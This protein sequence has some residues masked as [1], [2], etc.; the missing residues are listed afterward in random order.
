[1]QIGIGIGVDRGGGVR[2]PLA[3]LAALYG[4]STPGDV[5]LASD[6]SRIW[7]DAG[8]TPGAVS[9]SI[10]RH[11]GARA[12]GTPLQF[13]QASS[14]LRPRLARV[15]RGG[16]RNRLTWT[17]DLTNAIW[18]KS[19]VTVTPDAQTDP[20]GGLADKII[21]TAVSGGK[22][23][24]HNPGFSSSGSWTYSR[25]VK[26]DGYG[27]FA[28]ALANSTA[29]AAWFNLSTGAITSVGANVTATSAVSLGNGWW[30]VS[31]TT[32]QA[33]GF[34]QEYVSNA[35]SFAAM[36]GDGVSGILVGSAQWEDGA[37]ATAYQ[38]VSDQFDVTEAGV[39]TVWQW[40][41]D[42]VDDV[43]SA[44]VSFGATAMDVFV[45][46]ERTANAALATDAA[47]SATERFGMTETSATTAPHDGAGTPAYYVN[48]TLVS[49]TQRGALATA[50]PVNS[51]RIVEARG[52]DLNTWANL[53]LGFY[54]SFA[55]LSR[56]R[57]IMAIDSTTAAANRATIMAA[58]AEATGV[59]L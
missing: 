40:A 45:V 54:T 20:T 29:N 43:I 7:Q 4:A 15:P 55:G 39:E 21:P 8:V 47:G 32:A 50:W 46:G 48:G 28:I 27:F 25:Y 35:A 18:G 49:P 53:T 16:R 52:L 19:Q 23:W 9:Q 36:T 17:E 5:W 44:P 10:G 58:L 14:G 56:V 2:S 37:T 26:A 51:Q 33:I 3:R 6:L 34:V 12:A 1:M 13:N 22:S 31:L 59:T 57:A 41:F 24:T 11:T 30:R 42:Q 38:R